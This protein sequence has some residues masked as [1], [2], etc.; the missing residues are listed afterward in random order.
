MKLLHEFDYPSLYDCHSAS[1]MD[2]NFFIALKLKI[3][4]TSG[5]E[6]RQK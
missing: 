4:S 3:R 2:C 6:G 5:T 1:L